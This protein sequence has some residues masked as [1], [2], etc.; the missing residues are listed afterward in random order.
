MK[1]RVLAGLAAFLLFTTPTFATPAMAHPAIQVFVDGQAIAFDQAPVIVEDRTLVPMRAI[2]QAFGSM[3]TWSEPEQLV[4]S[5]KGS[6]TVTLKIGEAGLY[7]NGQLIDTMDVPARIVNDRTM[8]PLRA[9]AQAFDAEVAWD[10][11]AYVI[12]IT[13]QEADA[14]DGYSASVKAADGTTV[15]TFQ[16]DFAKSGGSYGEA[17]QKTLQAEAEALAGDFLKAY[18]EKAKAAY[19]KTKGDEF[20]PYSFVGSYEMTREDAQFVSFYGTTSQYIGDSS[21]LKGSLSHTF[22]A[23]DGKELALSDVVK[24]SKAELADFL[25]TSFAALIEESPASF[26]EDGEKRLKAS[27][28]AVGFYLTA[29]GIGFYLPPETIA[30]KEAGSISF[31]VKYEF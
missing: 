14:E 25:E 17:M 12:T 19:E 21:L 5:T 3:I 20:Q 28:D 24:D 18:G 4:T 6:D 1:K 22:S 11:A 8:V 13:S 27:L 2:F 31:T 10:P 29:T 16:M 15:L 23:K 9:V 30:P 7:K 26:Y